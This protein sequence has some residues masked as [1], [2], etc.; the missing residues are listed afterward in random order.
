MYSQHKNVKVFKNGSIFIP[1][2]TCATIYFSLL[3]VQICYD[4]ASEGVVVVAV[5]HRDGS[6][7][8]SLFFQDGSIEEVSYW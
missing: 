8:N 6:A 4:L 5:E 2:N 3:F 1:K 7:S